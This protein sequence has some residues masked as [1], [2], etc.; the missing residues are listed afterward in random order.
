[1][2]A[3]L[4]VITYLDRICIAVAGPHIQNDLHISP[5][6][7]GWVTG[8]FSLSYAAFEIPT[9]ALGDRIGARRVLTRV[10]VWWSAFTSLTGV[11]SSYPLL[12]LTRFCFGAGEA[13]AYPNIA[14]VIGRWIPVQK[15]A[16][17]WGLVWMMSQIG[18]AISPVLVV[19]IQARYGWRASFWLFGLLGVA[20]SAAWFWWYR[21]SPREKSGVG[22]AEFSELGWD[23]PALHRGLPWRDA[24]RSTTLWQVMAIT[25]C[26]GYSM[27]FF[28]AWLPTYLSK[29]R[30]YSDGA[31][32]WSAIPF[33]VG[34]C[35]NI[36]GGFVSDRL[37]RTLGLRAGRRIVGIVGLG[38]STACM[39]GVIVTTNNTLLLV[40]LSIAYGGMTLQ[41]PV[42]C[43]VALDVGKRHAGAVLGFGNTASNAAGFLSSIAFG[44]IAQWSGSY[45]APLIPMVLMLLAGVA[46][47]LRIDASSGLFDSTNPT[48]DAASVH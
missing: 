41:Q 5:S 14:I 10:V 36:L 9:G 26:Y 47:W 21:D 31:L 15:R 28:Q 42:I 45:Q 30:G 2:L 1:M 13:G 38:M 17:A 39:A 27:Q 35:T 40:L 43:A 25:A 11:V 29:G 7:W 16:R 34:A 6:A 12:L 3:L 22:E 33:I 19:P 44:Y 48:L 24:L 23:L 46:V 18:G 20:W 37:V 32:A 8:I 4:A